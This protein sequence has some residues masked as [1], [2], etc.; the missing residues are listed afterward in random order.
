VDEKKEEYNYVFSSV[1]VNG[2]AIGSVIVLSDD[3]IDEFDEK[4]ANF[5][6]KFLSKHL[7]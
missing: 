1:I 2:D 4:S 7:E 5:I 3:E 6:S